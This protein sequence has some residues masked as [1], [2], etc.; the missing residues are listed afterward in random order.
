MF[1]NRNASR[2]VQIIFLI[3]VFLLALTGCNDEALDDSAAGDPDEVAAEQPQQPEQPHGNTSGNI[4]NGG[5]VAA[6]SGWV[7]FSIPDDAR[8]IKMQADGSGKQVISWE[9]AEF[10]NVIDDWVY[11]VSDSEIIKIRTDGSER[12]VID[13]RAFPH[14]LY[15]VGEW[16]YYYS[17]LNHETGEG[18]YKIR[19]DGEEKTLIHD[20]RA[21][22]INILGEWIYFSNMD[23]NYRPY[24]IKID[25]TEPSRVPGIDA[26]NLQLYENTLYYTNGHTIHRASIESGTSSELDHHDTIYNF[27][28]D[29]GGIYYFTPTSLHSGVYNLKKIDI[30]S[31]ETEAIG[32]V[33]IS[34]ENVTISSLNLTDDWIYILIIKEDAL[35]RVRTDGSNLEV[36]V[37]ADTEIEGPDISEEDL[38]ESNHYIVDVPSLLALDFESAKTLLD[39][40]FAEPPTV[41]GP[42]EYMGTEFSIYAYVDLIEDSLVALSIGITDLEVTNPGLPFIY[43]ALGTI[44]GFPMDYD[45]EDLYRMTGIVP[46]ATEY[47]LEDVEIT[48]N[49]IS[50]KVQQTR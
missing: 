17:V 5:F 16:A 18:L 25:G 34:D 24:K 9:E 14:Y 29:D 3:L 37:T 22:D 47:S 41:E 27:I 40:Y 10:I 49:L 31:E 45:L 15:V 20:S 42:Q 12:T 33:E 32:E 44:E 7:Y 6:S 8:L 21:L 35:Y 46:N 11:Y 1:F 43:V 36:V 28:I 2:Y 38:T 48:D 39:Q 19:T 30:S 50:F 4:N 26:F 13:A 23:D